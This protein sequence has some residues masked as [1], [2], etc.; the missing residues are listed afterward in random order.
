MRY[1]LVLEYDGTGFHGWQIQPAVRTVQGELEGALAQVGG[2]PVRCEGAGRTDAG[3]HALAQVASFSLPRAWEPERL[4]AAL[5]SRLPP[6]L[7]ALRAGPA[8]DD[9]HA[10]HSA[11]WKSYVYQIDE[12]PVASPFWRRYAHNVRWPLDLA[13]MQAGAQAFLGVH[14]FASFCAG[15]DPAKPT[16]REVRALEIARGAELL[17]IRI[18]ASGFLRSMARRMVGTL[19]QVGSG[20]LE[21]AAVSAILG[22]CDRAAAGPTAPAKGLFLERVYYSADCMDAP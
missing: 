3:V 18:L 21:A 16:M 9:F 6:D 5:N 7:R 14:D 10:R 19:L 4:V 8:P 15:E 11:R 1:K 2:A 17:R 12:R 20:R 13:E 22:A